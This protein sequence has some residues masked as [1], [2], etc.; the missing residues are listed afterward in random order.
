MTTPTFGVA[1]N[2]PE[3]EPLPVIGADFS[4]I[5]IGTT[6]DDA[7]ATVLP[8]GVAKRFSSNDPVFL[9]GIGYRL[10]GR[11]HSRHQ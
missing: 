6:S 2:R 7:N 8:V 10:P 5:G 1:I 11:R 9:G 3:V 4:R